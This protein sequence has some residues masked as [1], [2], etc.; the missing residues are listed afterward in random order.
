MHRIYAPCA[1]FSQKTVVIHDLSEIHHALDVIRLETG[2]D[3]IIFDGNGQEA[4]GQLIQSDPQSL[5]VEIDSHRRFVSN[6]P[7]ITLA[8]AIPKRAKFETIIEKTTE[9]GVDE[10]IPLITQ[11][12]Q[13]RFTQEQAVKKAHRFYAVAINAAKQCQR[14]VLPRIHPA[15]KYEK[16]FG[17]IKEGPNQGAMLFIPC[18][19]A[20]LRP[21]VQVLPQRPL[22]KRIIFFIGPEGD[23]TPSEINMACVNGC[24]PVSLGPTTLKVDTAAIAVVAFANFLIDS[25]RMDGLSNAQDKESPAW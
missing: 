13:V 12:T 6:R 5:I 17:L 20:N 9:L 2:Q 18:L 10:I 19:A 22:P 25:R 14:A 8:C 21:L 15:V 3:V 24:V 16:C 23:F 11:R 7:W 1:D 4:Q